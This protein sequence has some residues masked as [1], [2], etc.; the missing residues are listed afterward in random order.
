[1]MTLDLITLHFSSA[2]SRCAYVLVFLVVALSQRQQTHL[3]QWAAAMAASMIGSFLMMGV[4][5]DQLPPVPTAIFTHALYS[6][7]LVLSWTGL[8]SFFGRPV[9][10]GFAAGTVVGTTLLYPILLEFA[11]P[12]LAIAAVLA[13]CLGV[14]CLTLSE[15]LRRTPGVARLWSQHFVTLAFGGFGAVFAVSIGLMLGTDMPI[16]SAEGARFAMVLDQIV[17]VFIY[18]GYAA[19]AAERANR[20]LQHL[21]ETDPLTGLWNRRGL[22]RRLDRRFVRSGPRPQAGILILDIDH[23][24]AIN[25]RHGH[26]GGDLVLEA[27][28]ARMKAALRST[29]LIARWGGEEFL[30]VLPGTDGPE[31]L[32]IAE[33]LR[34]SLAETPFP[35]PAGPLAVTASI[36]AALMEPGAARFEE[37]TQRADAA[38]YAA[39]L[40]GRNRVVFGPSTAPARGP[41]ASMPVADLHLA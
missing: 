21:A 20:A 31:L 26:E 4:P 36:G 37:A 9:P 19:M 5:P 27:F 32:R 15:T 18:F 30:A 17:G 2:A 10:I 11:G 1:M 35:L 22:A 7:S 24:K 29:D 13:C 38:L 34:A 25:D 23:F 28:A 16:A 40:Q 12:R 3:W 6:A 8:R 14:V 39:K 33:R 41:A